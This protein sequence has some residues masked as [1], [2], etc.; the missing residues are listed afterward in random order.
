[1]RKAICDMT[2]SELAS[3]Y[4]YCLQACYDDNLEPEERSHFRRRSDAVKEYIL[5]ME[6]FS[7]DDLDAVN[8]YVELQNG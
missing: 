5:L 8:K 1:M 6:Y 3:E 2:K 4:L 7:K